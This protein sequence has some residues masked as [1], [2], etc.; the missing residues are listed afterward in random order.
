MDILISRETLSK[1]S[2]VEIISLC[3]YFN[4]EWR[5][6]IID[7]KTKKQWMSEHLV[8]KEYLLDILYEKREEMGIV[9]RMPK[10]KYEINESMKVLYGEFS[11]S[12]NE[13]RSICSKLN[14]KFNKRTYNLLYSIWLT[15]KT[16]TY[17]ELSELLSNRKIFTC[18]RNRA[19][20]KFNEL[21]HLLP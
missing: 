17:K 14:I 2:I 6:L 10:V 3:S 8:S 13:C 18:G 21:V 20:F 16:I 19:I 15:N 12:S 9:V 7:V 4:I 5:T 1:L 11:K